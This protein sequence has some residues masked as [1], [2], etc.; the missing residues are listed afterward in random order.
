MNTTTKNLPSSKSESVVLIAQ[1]SA[2]S[3]A[4]LAFYFQ[5]LGRPTF[6]E[7]SPTSIAALRSLAAMLPCVV[8][9]G[10][11]C[12]RLQWAPTIGFIT[13]IAM[14][15]TVGSSSASTVLIVGLW[16]A[17]LL[18]CVFAMRNNTDGVLATFA[19]LKHTWNQGFKPLAVVGLVLLLLSSPMLLL[20]YGFAYGPGRGDHVG[21]AP[22]G[23]IKERRAWAKKEMFE[24]F[25]LTDKWVRESTM[26]QS[27]IGKVIDVAPIGSPNRFVAG[28]F[29]D[30]SHCRMNLQVI[31]ERG[32]GVLYL[33]VVDVNNSYQLYD[34]SPWS[35]WTFGGKTSTMYHSGKSWIESSDHVELIAEIRN[36]SA[37][38]DHEEV[39][40]LCQLLSEL[41]N[42][43]LAW[44]NTG[45][46]KQH[47]PDK[48]LFVD[49]PKT[50]RCEILETYGK[51]LAATGDTEKATNALVQCAEVALKS[52]HDLHYAE[53]QVQTRIQYGAQYLTIANNALIAAEKISP[54]QEKVLKLAR[55]RTVH[56]MLFD[57]DASDAHMSFHSEEGEKR[58]NMER[59]L[60]QFIEGAKYVAHESKWLRG[61]MGTMRIRPELRRNGDIF[62]NQEGYYQSARVSVEVAGT[63]GRSGCLS[64]RMVELKSEARPVDLFSENPRHPTFNFTFSRVNWKADGDSNETR[65]STKTLAPK[66]PKSRRKQ[67]A[68]K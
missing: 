9:I 62:L 58:E 43:D 20:M 11:F 12:L 63:W 41:I 68:A 18:G 1:I 65:L 15:L 13:S 25:E 35:T 59:K 5:Y 37:D 54:R 52:F 38:S 32:E 57:L 42:D 16:I 67:V 60:R 21:I 51:S 17:T 19:G 14:L 56:K 47:Y 8:L 3:I 10:S 6:S 44:E 33:P 28:G 40:G 46:R 50:Y 29:T 55:K 36:R 45:T 39:I 34:V 53:F 48:Q 22:E 66:P 49:M 31:G 2:L 26:I 4:V 30:G 27:D 7:E 24:Y 23:S 64:M 61:K